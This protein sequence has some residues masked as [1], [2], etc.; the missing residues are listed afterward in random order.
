V[1]VGSSFGRGTAPGRAEGPG[2]RLRYQVRKGER[3]PSRASII[4]V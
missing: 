1:R 2:S 4:K 3:N